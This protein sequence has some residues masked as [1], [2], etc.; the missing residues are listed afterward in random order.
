[1]LFFSRG[2]GGRRPLPLG[3]RHDCRKKAAA[4]RQSGS[5]FLHGNARPSTAIFAE[6]RLARHRL[7]ARGRAGAPLIAESTGGGLL[8][9]L[10]ARRRCHGDAPNRPERPREADR[11]LPGPGLGLLWP[12]PHGGSKRQDSMWCLPVAPSGP[13]PRAVRRGPLWCGP[14]PGF[15]L[16]LSERLPDYRAEIS[17]SQ[18]SQPSASLI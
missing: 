6:R 7:I 4:Q 1:M 12:G 18:F 13:G 3:V 5:H 16:F 8:C 14:Q 2:A 11:L 10:V 15:L 17:L 9:L